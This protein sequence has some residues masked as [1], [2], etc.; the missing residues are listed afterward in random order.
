MKKTFFAAISLLLPVLM[1]CV[2][3]EV[4]DTERAGSE[5]TSFTAVIGGGT[6]RSDV[7]DDGDF[8]WTAGD[9]VAVHVSGGQSSRFAEFSLNS[10]AG[11]STGTFKGMLNAGEEMSF[12]AVYPYN[13]GHSLEGG[14]LTVNLPAEY[15]DFTSDYIPDTNAP[16]VAAVPDNVQGD[17]HAFEFHHVAGVLR[18]VVENV[19][20]GASQFVF[21]AETGIAGRFE[22][23]DK[24][25]HLVIRAKEKADGNNKVTIRFKPTTASGTMRFFIPLPVGTYEGFSVE[26]MDMDGNCLASHLSETTNVLERRMLARYPKITLPSESECVPA[27]GTIMYD[28]SAAVHFTEVGADYF[29]LDDSFPEDRLPAVGNIVC[30]GITES[31]PSGFLGRVVSVS[32][33]AGGVRVT[34]EEVALDEAF[35]VLKVNETINMNEI[36]EGIFD[37]NGE[38]VEYE[39]VDSGIFE[40]LSKDPDAPEESVRIAPMAADDLTPWLSLDVKKEG[41]YEGKVILDYKL[42]V[43]INIEPSKEPELD[44]S[45][46][47]RTAL[48]GELIMDNAEREYKWPPI[49]ELTIPIKASPVAAIILDP[50]IKAKIFFTAKGEVKLTSNVR[51]VMNYTQFRLKYENGWKGG[52]EDLSEKK[53]NYF[54][55]ASLEM[56]GEAGIKA[57]MGLGVHLFSSKGFAADF[58]VGAKLMWKPEAAFSLSH[59]LEG[60]FDNSLAFELAVDA[61]MEGKAKVFGDVAEYELAV[62]L[63]KAPVEVPILASFSN[64]IAT[65]VNGLIKTRAVSDAGGFIN[66]SLDFNSR[67]VLE[68]QEEGIA[69]LRGNGTDDVLEHRPLTGSSVTEAKTVEFS[70]DD[71]DGSDYYVAPYVKHEGEYY[72][73]E[74][75]PVST[76]IREQLVRFYNAT[77]GDNWTNNENWCSDKPLEEWYGISVM[78]S[79]LTG[80]DMYT[81]NLRNNNLVGEAELHHEDI[82]SVNLENNSL[83]SLDLSGCEILSVLYCN[84]N[85]LES[86]DVSGCSYIESFESYGQGVL[87][88]LNLA[89]CSSLR[90]L[91]VGGNSLQSLD[92]SDCT[93]LE[94]I[95]C[96]NNSLLALVMP[97][98]PAPVYNIDCSGNSLQ[99]LDLSGCTALT[100]VSCYDNRIEFLDMSG[101]ASIRNVYCRNNALNEILLPPS[102]QHLERFICSLNNLPM[103]DL[104]GCASLFMLECDDNGITRLDLSGCIALEGV[105]CRNNPLESLDLSQCERI[106]H[107]D[108]LARGYDEFDGTGYWYDES[109]RLMS[110]NL[111][112]CSSLPLDRLNLEYG[113]MAELAVSGIPALESLYC[114]DGQ[115]SSL[116]VSKCDFLTEIN[117]RQNRLTGLNIA[118]CPVLDKVECSKNELSE[119]VITGCPSVT[120]VQC[121]GNRLESL[122]FRDCSSLK[123]LGCGE[124]PL[125]ALDL[126]AWRELEVL[127]LWNCGLESVDFSVA[128][129]LKEIYCRHNN[130]TEL[131]LDSCMELVSLDCSSNQLSSLDLSGHTCLRYVQFY[132]NIQL[133]R[134]D[135]SGCTSLESVDFGVY[136]PLASVDL[137]GCTGLMEIRPLERFETLTDLNLNGCAALTELNVPDNS[138]TSLGLEGCIALQAIDCKNNSLQELDLADCTALRRLDC[139]GNMITSLELTD[140]PELNSVYCYGNAMNSLILS[141]CGRLQTVYCQN[142]SLSTLDLDGC[143]SLNYLDCVNNRITREITAF[144][145]DIEDFFY[146]VRYT[147]YQWEYSEDADGNLISKLV[148]YTDN[149]VGWWYPGEPQS[150]KHSF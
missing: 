75:V 24:D 17:D 53:D 20:A 48:E 32:D 35:T 3:E 5:E 8:S 96:Q 4:R 36:V 141:G 15:G 62:S 114:P 149:G 60:N 50:E 123:T 117:C 71:S 100:D 44:F 118:D 93:S 65:K 140:Y 104:S 11:S 55:I 97:S 91:R 145:A 146:D 136:Y 125:P 66:A 45:F 81:I 54:K 58:K 38:P 64:L 1:G 130:F 110:L 51:Y 73:G 87:A 126:S 84:G 37:E 148:D 119:L 59:R 108:F 95:S 113:Q 68:T 43:K 19:P 135:L 106:S 133:E 116:Q 30:C 101:A 120:S 6:V 83:S 122:D 103:L 82:V 21:T 142:N 46:K 56:A 61:K 124:N 94:E 132:D 74:R 13:E 28:E 129:A 99:S 78:P 144:Y 52:V 57:E 115:L 105:P 22:T 41:V 23:V 150:G 76:D 80:K 111:T 7:T 98:G 72:Y 79:Y 88:D 143:E 9:A 12:Y 26:I 77:G 128:P 127:E 92:L 2:R 138:L 85:P 69:L 18:F 31:T 139:S 10:G 107:I 29:I 49:L 63:F 90:V 112:G 137:S 42:D 27:P 16:M 134:V 147:D 40:S 131:N 89:G 33:D 102:P 70:V 86:A 25:G 121:G 109:G 39:F 47:T 14:R 34:C 67:S